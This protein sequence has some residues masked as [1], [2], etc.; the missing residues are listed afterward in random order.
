LQPSSSTHGPGRR[1]SAKPDENTHSPM[2]G[3]ARMED[4]PAI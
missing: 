3:Q 2:M 4:A 1:R